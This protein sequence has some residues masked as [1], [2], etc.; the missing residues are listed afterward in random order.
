MGN[1]LL[2]LIIQKLL[3]NNM[4]DSGIFF[5]PCIKGKIAKLQAPYFVLFKF[6]AKI[7]RGF[8]T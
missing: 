4:D 6:N 5:F 1:D 3:L 2:F 8:L 7:L